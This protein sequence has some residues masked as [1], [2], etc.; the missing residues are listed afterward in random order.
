MLLKMPVTSP[1][2]CVQE[3]YLFHSSALLSPICRLF[4]LNVG[5]QYIID[6]QDRRLKSI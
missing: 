5:V 3:F 2:T 1:G 4:L 6:K